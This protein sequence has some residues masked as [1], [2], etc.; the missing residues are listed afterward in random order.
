MKQMSEGHPDVLWNRA[1]EELLC[2]EAEKCSGLSWLHT[3]S[4]ALYSAYNTRLQ[5]PIII[6]SALS[7]FVS[8]ILPPTV[9]G[10][11]AMIGSVSILV[12]VLGTINSFFA[13]ARRAEGHRIS[14]VQYSQICRSIRIE[15]NLPAE[16]RL[17]PKVMLKWIKDDLKRLAETSPRVPEKI[18]GAYR[19]EVIPHSEKASHPEIT[20][21]IESVEPFSEEALRRTP[22]VLPTPSPLQ[23]HIDSTTPT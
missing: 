12:S 2:N 15:M 6:F 19:K 16:Q 8:G 18:L 7:G 13:F 10:G 5:L 20:N 23:I 14:A 9:E 1:L 21:G 4:E 3:R 22:S 17:I 11:T